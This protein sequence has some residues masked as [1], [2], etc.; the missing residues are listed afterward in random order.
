M[1]GATPFPSLTQCEMMSP[2]CSLHLGSD[3][4]GTTY[5]ARPFS[6][7]YVLFWASLVAQSVKNPP[8]TQETQVQFL[9]WEDPLE[10]EM[11]THS[12][13]LVWQNPILDRGTRRATV[14]GVARVR[15]DLATKPP[16][17]SSVPLCKAEGIKA[18]SLLLY[19]LREMRCIVVTAQN[20]YYRR[21]S[22]HPTLAELV[23]QILT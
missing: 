8:A 7:S 15:H 6:F 16:P 11:A 20:V 17:A 14:H 4:T 13:I 5:R 18:D 3:H 9:V 1:Q 21:A 10:K 12:S 19:V 2:K 23:A 22:P